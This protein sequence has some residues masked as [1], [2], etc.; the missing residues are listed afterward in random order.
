MQ[1]E[2]E[3]CGSPDSLVLFKT[4]QTR[5]KPIVLPCAQWK[6]VID[7]ADAVKKDDRTKLDGTCGIPGRNGEPLSVYE[8]KMAEF[9]VRLSSK[10]HVP[11]EV[12][13]LICGRLYTGPMC[14]RHPQPLQR[15]HH[16]QVGGCTCGIR[17]S[18]H[19]RNLSN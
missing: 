12:E 16:S 6:Y 14:T 7:G 2:R 19:S 5:G 9:N 17:Q 15:T 8:H 3:H 1:L 10:G 18:H 11:L 4:P 13:E